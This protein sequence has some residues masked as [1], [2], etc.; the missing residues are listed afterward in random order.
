MGYRLVI[1]F[2][3][4]AN[5]IL[6]LVGYRA[7]NRSA[8]H[9]LLLS[10]TIIIAA[11]AVSNYF[12]VISS[13]P[14]TK[15]FW[16]RSVMLATAPSAL[17]IYLLAITYP[18]EKIPLG[19]LK[20]IFLWSMTFILMLLS[21]T[22]WMFPHLE[23]RDNSRFTLTPGPAAFLFALNHL[24]LIFASLWILFQRYRKL[25]GLEKVQIKFFILG[26][27]LTTVMS[28]I[29][30]LI[31]VVFLKTTA[32]T[33]IGP[34]FSLFMVGFISYAIVK[35][36]LLDIQLV[37]ARTVSYSI[38]TFVL[39]SLYAGLLYLIGNLFFEASSPTQ[40]WTS[41]VLAVILAYTFQPL[42]R[43]LERYT[44]R[45]FYKAQYDP[46]LLLSELNRMMVSTYDLEILSKNV[47]QKLTD[48]VRISR[49]ALVLLSNGHYGFQTTLDPKIQPFSHMPN[50]LLNQ[51]NHYLS[52]HDL[53]MYD[54]LPEGRLKAQLR[55]YQINMAV[56]LRTKEQYVGLLLVGEKASGDIYSEKDIHLF[57][58]FSS[59]LSIAIQNANAI[60]EISKFNKKLKEEV[61]RATE[62]LRKANQRLKL[63]DQLKDEFVSV[64]SHELR[65]PMTAI[66]SY[67]WLVLNKPQK[68]DHLST[69]TR[70][71]LE[72]AYQSTERLIAL[73]NDMLDVSRI[74]AGRIELKMEKL[75]MADLAQAVV[76]EVKP[77][78]D[79]KKLQLKIEYH[80]KNKKHYWVKADRDKIHQVLINL[81]GNALKF[82]PK[83]GKITILLSQKNGQVITQVIDTGKGISA[84]DQQKLFTKFGRVSHSYVSVAEAGGTGLGLYISKQ[85]VKMHRGDIWVKS[86]LNHGSTFGFSL[87]AV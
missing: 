23:I 27:G 84:E 48:T 46:Q 82:T 64:A 41:A 5:L 19:G 8:T 56:P 53:L 10:L 78:A 38:L 16:V 18:K 35:H 37:V 15:L 59:E 33:V 86:K 25:R 68:N 26:L 69:K 43:L 14:E 45:I 79:Q 65:T 57:E 17:V 13:D 40:V 80:P 32:F 63:L 7:N 66:K 87:P 72:R 21:Y 67:L 83:Q 6:G 28:A 74:E 50:K 42:R 31:F 71:Q 24:L 1:I 75:D 20:I 29:T 55:H 52:K 85:L 47:L 4:V 51:I 22:P 60:E 77:A 44:D 2:T 61:E 70:Q 9:R 54:D 36:R 39:L 81:V 73:V 30:N 76:A 34:F 49:L 11:W 12:S 3:V 62:D 58:I